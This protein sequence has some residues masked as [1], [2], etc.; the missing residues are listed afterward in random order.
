M[1]FEELGPSRAGV[2][3]NRHPVWETEVGKGAWIWQEADPYQRCDGGPRNKLTG[4]Y[5]KN[6]IKKILIGIMEA[7]DLW[8]LFDLLRIWIHPTGLARVGNVDGFH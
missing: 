7:L 3:S 1:D 2:F 4:Y 6:K 8:S 5:Y